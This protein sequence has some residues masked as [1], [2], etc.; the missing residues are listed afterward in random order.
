MRIYTL[1]NT[2]LLINHNYGH[3]IEYAVKSCYTQTRKPYAVVIVDD[4]STD[5]SWDLI[6]TDFRDKQ[7]VEEHGL[8][9]YRQ[10][11]DGILFLAVQLAKAG[12]PS[13]AR[14][15]GIDLT[16]NFTDNYQIL[17]S[18]DV[19]YPQKLEVLSNKMASDPNLGVVY[20]DYDILNVQTGNILR[21]WK[22]S[23]SQRRLMSECIIHSG[24]M[25]KKEA[26]M[27]VMEPTGY[28]DC[29][30]RCAEDWDLWLRLSD[31]CIIAHVP[32][33]LTLV[34]VHNNNSTNS[35]NKEIW[36]ACWNRVGQK[37]QARQGK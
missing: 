19:L 26:L 21:E 6:L 20:A 23:Y 35:V 34:R 31:R 1:N 15:I 18:D 32:Q 24:A 28:Y 36:Q 5:N 37:L 17:D 3:Y 27:A 7:Y 29:N 30:L 22:E 2:V 11:N 14:N 16:K 4:G 10:V 12:G 33:S 8:K 25:I 13:L 9:I